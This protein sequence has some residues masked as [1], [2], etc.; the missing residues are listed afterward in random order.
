MENKAQILAELKGIGPF[1]AEMVKAN[2]Y[3]LPAGYFTT[4]PENILEKIEIG[5]ICKEPSTA[6]FEVPEGYFD[7]FTGN[8]FSKI[9]ESQF[10]DNAIQSELAEIAPL[11]NTLSKKN[12]YAVPTGYFN[13]LA[14]VKP[15]REK[16]T[17]MRS[18]TFAKKWTQYAAAAIMTGLLVTSAFLFT[19]NHKGANSKYDNLN[20]PSELNKLS[21]AELVT[22]LDNPEHA[23]VTNTEPALSTANQA[24]ADV[25]STIQSVSDEEL[26]QY[27]RENGDPA[28]I[29]IP[30]KNN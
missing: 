24:L 4:L 16:E 10:T 18:F 19:D 20:M 21:E 2:P 30:V 27:L 1:L 13:R 5:G 22:Y 3:T 15:A 23:V 9:Q 29:I 6:I 14:F 26:N 8:I 11:L 7:G 17:K 28:D 12:I 25:K